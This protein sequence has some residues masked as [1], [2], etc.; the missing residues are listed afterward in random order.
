MEP[1]ETEESDTDKSRK[2]RTEIKRLS[3]Q[4]NHI[5]MTTKNDG[6]E[7]NSILTQNNQL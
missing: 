6:T 1:E 2:I 4:R 5:T 3:D 7:K